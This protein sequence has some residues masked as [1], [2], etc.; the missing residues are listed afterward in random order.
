MDTILSTSTTTPIRLAVVGTGG[1]GKLHV[2]VAAE[3]PT[4]EL[5]VI[6]SLEDDG[7]ALAEGLDI[8]FE[9]DYR[10]LVNHDI[11]A[12]LVATPN[13]T[14]RDIGAFFAE[15]GVHVLMEKPIADTLASAR[16]LCD[17]AEDGGVQLLIGHHRRHHSLVQA[18]REF[19]Q[20]SLGT[21][22][23]TNTLVTMQKPDSYYEVAWRREAGAGPLLVN[24]IHEV[25][26]LRFI[27]GEIRAVQAVSA[28]RNR[29]FA[30]DD[31]AVVL[32]T[33][34][35]GAMGTLTITES[36]ASP[37]SWE[38]SMSDG[39]G[40]FNAGQ[41][42]AQFMGTNAALSFPS[43]TTWRYDSSE[44][45]PGWNSTLHSKPL[46]PD[47]TNPYVE[48]LSHFA[49]VVRGHAAP[50]VSGP[51]ALRSLAVVNAVMLAAASGATVEIDDVVSVPKL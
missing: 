45:E 4:I 19:V 36:A 21:P 46:T 47:R 33:Y 44:S 6:C 34:A 11:E 22:L 24:L 29:K 9:K 35:S 37:W 39:L 7:K 38:A 48:Q 42:H 2:Q 10:Q 20:N 26:L 18:A 13:Q 5:V 12:V 30:F 25:D 51:D 27:S 40:F 16:S 49:D 23:S 17:A 14:H 41:D 3:H 15:A 43:L 1:I 8:A 32:V 50:L 28:K 31:T